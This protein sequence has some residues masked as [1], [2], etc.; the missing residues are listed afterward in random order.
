MS[1]ATGHD[2]LFTSVEEIVQCVRPGILLDA[3]SVPSVRMTDRHG[4][5]VPLNRY[6]LDYWGHTQKQP[7]V[8]ANGLREGNWQCLH[9]HIMGTLP[10]DRHMCVMLHWGLVL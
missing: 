1:S 5:V 4:R 8:T 9:V 7:L 6:I 3:T 2:E 10:T